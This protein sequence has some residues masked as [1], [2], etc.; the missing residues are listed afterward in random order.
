MSTPM[1]LANVTPSVMRK[2][3]VGARVYAPQ[4]GGVRA[5]ATTDDVAKSKLVALKG[6]DGKTIELVPADQVIV[7][8]RWL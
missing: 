4:F 2:L 1:T 8:E 5:L 6:K 7:I 3:S